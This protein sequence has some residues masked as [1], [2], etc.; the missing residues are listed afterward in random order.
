MNRT[1]LKQHIG[2][3]QLFSLAAFFALP[4]VSGVYFPLFSQD[5]LAAILAFEVGVLIYGFYLAGF[6]Y[7]PIA[8]V[9]SVWVRRICL[10]LACLM[11]IPFTSRYR[12]LII[13]LI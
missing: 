2:T 5:K 13:E 8:L 10:L 4:L 12:Q 3:F 9:D 7:L 1:F 11:A 6:L